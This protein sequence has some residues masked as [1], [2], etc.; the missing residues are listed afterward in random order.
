PEPPK[1]PEGRP[2][3][4]AQPPAQPRPE[5]ARPAEPPAQP[6]PEPRPTEPKTEPRTEPKPRPAAA[7]Q[8]L[9]RT[10][11]LARFDSEYDAT[12]W[13][14]AH[15]ID[16]RVDRGWCS[17]PRARAPHRFVFALE[18]SARL[19]KLA[20]D[21][22]CPE[23][24]GFEGVSAA[25]FA[26]EV[27]TDGQDGPYRPALEGTLLR[28]KNDQ[29]FELQPPVEARWVRLTIRSNHGHPTLTE[30]MGVRAYAAGE[31]G[32]TASAGEFHLDRVR[33]SRAKNG[34]PLEGEAAAFQAGE[35]VWINVKPRGLSVGPEE[36]AWLEIDLVLEDAQGRELLRRDRVVDHV[37]RPPAPPLT[38]FVS[39]HLDL[40]RDFPP[41]PYAVRLL[42]RDRIAQTS[43]AAV[44]PFTVR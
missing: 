2:Q 12:L 29:V 4:P 36:K 18:R 34:P 15:L 11:T 9:L 42:A 35:R 21:N 43:A 40:P 30:L 41:G 23:E 3:P 20:F 22:A 10:A 16:G 37:A 31:A 39:L 5:P 26:V 32:P 7:G 28:G 6:K 13:A 1:P 33:A 27:S 17:S 8:E 14:A 24:E 44:C 38:P 19:A 25:G